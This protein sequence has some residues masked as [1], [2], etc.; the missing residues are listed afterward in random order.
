MDDEE[1]AESVAKRKQAEAHGYVAPA[2]VTGRSRTTFG[3]GLGAVDEDEDDFFSL[4]KKPVNNEDEDFGDEAAAG[5]GTGTPDV[6]PKRIHKRKAGEGG[7]CKSPHR[8]FGN[9]E[10]LIILWQHLGNR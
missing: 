3:D 7:D 1:L 6:K 4:A 5:S 8:C 9:K 2:I 10:A